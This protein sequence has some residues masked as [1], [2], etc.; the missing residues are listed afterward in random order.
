MV[1]RRSGLGRRGLDS[2]IPSGPGPGSL[3]H[4]PLDLITPN[5]D[6]PAPGSTKTRSRRWRRASPRS[7]SC[8]RWW[9]ARVPRGYVL[10]AGERRW[11]VPQVAGAARSRRFFAP[12][13]SAQPWPRRS[14]R[15]SSVR[16]SPRS[17]R[18][19]A[20]TQLLEDFAM[21]HEQVG[22]LVGKSRAAV[23]NTL[24]LLSLPPVIQDARAKRAERWSRQ[25]AGQGG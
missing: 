24:R 3:H 10:I 14:W 13:T 23:T 6:Q 19:A 7:G 2:L 8:S 11:R 22:A 9:C 20:Y 18:A 1:T 15:T 25:G 12:A 5:P 16:I 21:T 4:L 17:R